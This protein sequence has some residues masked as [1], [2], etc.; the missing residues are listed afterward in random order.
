MEIP[1]MQ[2]LIQ[3]ETQDKIQHIASKVLMADYFGSLLGFALFSLYLLHQFGLHFANFSGACL[4]FL[5]A[6]IVLFYR[7]SNSNTSTR[8]LNFVIFIALLGIGVN[9]EQLMKIA[10]Q[11]LYSHKIIWSQQTPYQKL[12]LTDLHS[13]KSKQ[14]NSHEQWKKKLKPLHSFNSKYSNYELKQDKEKNISFF[15]NG[16]LQFNSRDEAFYHEFLIHPACYL[17]PDFN[18]A[19]IMGGGDGLALRE[20]LKYDQLQS[21]TIVDLD[22]IMIQTFNSHPLL[23][24][25]NHAAFED[26]RVEIITEDA[27]SFIRNTKHQYDLI[28]LDFPDPHHSQTAKLYTKQFYSLIQF[29]LKPKGIL[30]TQSTSPLLDQEAF[31]CIRKTLEASHFNVLPCHIEMKSFFQWGFQICSKELQSHELKSRLINF[32][33]NISLKFLNRDI[34]YASTL[35]NRLFWSNYTHTPVNEFLS[36]NILELYT[37]A[38]VY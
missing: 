19:L 18:N 12:T 35:W 20:I 32:K 30:V 25:L 27:W 24:E 17:K 3:M 6:N 9:L 5:I 29:C 16:G 37:K 26:P 21:V 4:N 8:I 23:K 1:I 38:N 11:E 13:V 28:F 2:K 34:V 7:Y 36:L 22:P 33:T 31:M 14:R 15:I 10:E